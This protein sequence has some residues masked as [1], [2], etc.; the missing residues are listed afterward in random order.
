MARTGVARPGNTWATPW[1]PGDDRYGPLTA[2]TALWRP[3][4]TVGA[5]P[6]GLACAGSR[7]R[8]AH[9]CAGR[10]RA[11]PDA[12]EGSVNRSASER[13]AAPPNAAVTEEVRPVHRT[14]SALRFCRM[15]RGGTAAGFA[16]AG[17]RLRG[18]PR[19]R[20]TALGAS[21]RPG[22]CRKIPRERARGCAAQFDRSGGSLTG[23]P[24]G[25][26][27]TA[28]EKS[29]VSATWLYA[30]VPPCLLWLR[31]PSR[32]RRPWSTT[33]KKQALGCDFQ[34]D[35]GATD[36]PTVQFAQAVLG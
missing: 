19:L 6:R 17:S 24:D 33:P 22:R 34:L 2:R 35:G 10:R 20:R 29:G 8:T 4:G 16:C 32:W 15:R 14:P 28:V 9:A 31:C 11:L 18:R 36:T 26:R 21:R 5:L 23:A 25:E 12:R 30:P 13:G 7:L 1:L 27:S 3:R